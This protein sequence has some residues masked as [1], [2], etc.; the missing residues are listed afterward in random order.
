MSSILA[1]D[2]ALT[3]AFALPGIGEVLDER[4]EIIT[5]LGEGGMGHVFLAR[6]RWHRREVALKLIIPRYLGRPEREERF[7]RE[8]E[9]GRRV[10][11]HPHLVEM[12]DGGRLRA[13]GWPFLVMEPV[14]GQAL[15]NQ[16]ALGSLRAHVAARIARQIAS[17]ISALHRRGVVHRDVTPMNVLVHHNHAVLIDLSHA[18]DAAAPRFPIG[19]P[20]RLTRENEVPGSHIYMSP[21]QARAEPAQPA[22]DVYGF[23]VTLADML[24]GL[25]VDNSSREVFIELQREGKV[26]PP[27]IDTRV[28]TKVPPA[29]AELVEACTAA[30]PSDRPTV[31]E[32][33]ARLDDVLA[34]MPA[35]MEVPT[36]ERSAI[37]LELEPIRTTE[38]MRARPMVTTPISPPPPLDTE[39]TPV[40]GSPISRVEQEPRS[41]RGWVVMA[42]VVVLVVGLTIAAALWW[43]S[44]PPSTASEAEAESDVT[45]RFGAAPEPSAPASEPTPRPDPAAEPAEKRPAA[46]P[47]EPAPVP[48]SP[49]STA[50]EAPAK[51]EEEPKRKP[52]RKGD[53]KPSVPCTD[54][55]A[56]ATE[57]SQ[58]MRWDRV[59]ALTKT[60]RCWNDGAKRIWL[61]VEALSELGRFAECVR[62]GSS[63]TQ[64]VVQRTVKHCARQLEEKGTP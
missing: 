14:K 5:V 9:L 1:E 4:F 20:R 45:R 31:D 34:T 15:A 3:A 21:E 46:T 44:R 63:S 54:V 10:G 11:R 40:G 62:V 53:A 57:A 16:V 30:E 48:T 23:G 38:P 64:P 39:E 60:S 7:L 36:S 22:M 35:P 6:D 37:G 49:P 41:S 50:D 59:L 42:A 55:A 12:I 47:A 17:A 61:R 29:L 56:E 24:A 27:R 32:I 8:L 25:T 28:H 18:G 2:T 43:S 51:V 58:A 33:V 19:H 13:S 26:K 52:S